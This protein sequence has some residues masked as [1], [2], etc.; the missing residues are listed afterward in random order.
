MVNEN[1]AKLADEIYDNAI[2]KLKIGVEKQ[3]KGFKDI[4]IKDLGLQGP[5]TRLKRI[6]GKDYEIHYTTDSEFGIKLIDL[7]GASP[8]FTQFN[9]LYTEFINVLAAIDTTTDPV[10]LSQ[11]IHDFEGIC[12]HIV[13]GSL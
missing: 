11:L 10:A 5:L 7:I 12:E 9:K 13:S 4:L 1:S 8:E 2:R 6:T 3:I